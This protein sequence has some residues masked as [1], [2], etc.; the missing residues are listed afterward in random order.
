MNSIGIGWSASGDSELHTIIE[1]RL[2]IR[3]TRSVKAVLRRQNRSTPKSIVGCSMAK[4][5]R[6][7]RPEPTRSAIIGRLDGQANASDH[8]GACNLLP[9]CRLR[10][11]LDAAKNAFYRQLDRFTLVDCLAGQSLSAPERPNR[12]RQRSSEHS[13]RQRRKGSR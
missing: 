9:R 8:G 3:R 13:M 10:G 5:A 1:I 7:I 11:M 2:I 4:F 12:K 6:Q